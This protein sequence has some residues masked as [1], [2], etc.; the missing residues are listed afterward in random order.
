PTGSTPASS[1]RRCS[2]SRRGLR[3][4]RAASPAAPTGRPWWRRTSVC[5]G[6]ARPFPWAPA[7]RPPPSWYAR[8]TL[9]RAR[10][11]VPWLRPPSVLSSLSRGATSQRFCSAGSGGPM[12][13]TGRSRARL[14]DGFPDATG[15]RRHQDND[16]PS[17]YAL[18]CPSAI[19]MLRGGLRAHDDWGEVSEGGQRP[20]PSW[21]A[22]GVEPVWADEEPIRLRP[23]TPHELTKLRI[24]FAEQMR[25]HQPAHHRFATQ[26]RPP[27]DQSGNRLRGPSTGWDP[28]FPI[29]PAEDALDTLTRGGEEPPH[30]V[31]GDSE[32]QID[33]HRELEVAQLAGP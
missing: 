3:H 23:P 16:H 19:F 5:V 30:S 18:A 32:A 14:G 25:I 31:V 28:Q 20:P 15:F 17:C 27:L 24:L 26:P 6:C 4:A 8:P 29:E 13:G 22:V 7:H 10:R 1:T 12:R 9:L 11:L 21:L 33:Q 2:P